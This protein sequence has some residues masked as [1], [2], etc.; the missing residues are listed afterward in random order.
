MEDLNKNLELLSSVIQKE[1]LLDNVCDMLELNELQV[2]GL[3]VELKKRGHNV[4][5]I[6]RNGD[7][8]IV[9]YGDNF[10][11]STRTYK[12]DVKQKKF[13]IAFVSDTRFCSKFQQ[14]TILNDIYKKAYDFGVKEVFHCGDMSE[15]TYTGKKA[16]YM[17]TLFAQG[18]IDQKKYIVEHYPYAKGI[19]THFITGEHDQTHLSKEKVDIGKLITNERDDMNYLGKNNGRVSFCTPNGEALSMFVLHPKGKIPYTI[20][21]KPQQFISAMRSEDKTDILLHGH[22]LQAERMHFRS[23]DE[24]SVPSVVATTPEM[25]D[26]GDQNCIGAWF[27]TIE[28]DDKGKLVKTVPLFIPYYTTIED[29]YNKSKILSIGGRK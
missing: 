7:L 3:V 29:D 9:D 12:I 27:L 10:I 13:K 2:M 6:K 20:S 8:Y 21:Y 23:I 28:L 17:D 19:R 24:Y 1:K 18:V 16:I 15:G 26:N 14:L 4:L 5:E 22:W 11:E 25:L